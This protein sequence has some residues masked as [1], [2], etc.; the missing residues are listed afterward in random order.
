MITITIDEKEVKTEQG[1]TILEAANSAGI[2]IPTFCW[3]EKLDLYGGCRLCLVEVDELPKLQPACATYVCEG[4]KVSTNSPKVVKARKGVLEF[5]LINH[6][7][8][9]PTC[10]KA[11]ECELQDQV[12]KYGSDFTRFKEKKRRFKVDPK[13][14]FDDLSIGPQMIRNMNRCILCTRCIRFMKDIAGEHKLG[15][16]NRGSK[17]QINALPGIP[18]ANQYAGNVTEICP[19]GALTSKAFRYKTRVWLTKVKNS[20]CP[21]CGDGCNITLWVKDDKIYRVTSRRND[22]VDEGFLCDKGR[23]GYAFVNHPQ[24]ITGPLVKKEGKFE[25]ITWE[26]AFETVASKFKSS[27]QEF[28]SDSLAGVGSPNLTNEDN[29]VFQKFLR[30]AVGTNNIDHRID[31]K[32]PLPGPSTGD[33][34][35][36]YS[37]TNSIEDIEKAKAILVLGC[38]M[39]REHPIIAL[40][41]RKA[42]R[43]S[44]AALILLNPRKTRLRNAATEELVYRYGSEVAL[45]NCLLSAMIEQGLYA[46]DKIS[47]EEIKDLK[48]WLETYGPGKVGEITGIGSEKIKKLAKTLF[49]AE[50]IIILSGREV[51]QHHQNKDVIDSVLNILSLSGKMGKKGC[52]F[53]LLWETCNSQG[54]LDTGILPDRLPG[55]ADVKENQGLK[56]AQMLDAVNQGKIKA[57]Y[58][59]GSDPVRYFPDRNYV[60]STLKKLDFL[61]VQDI[62]LTQTAKMADVVLPG[63]SFAEKEGTFTS[64]E[65]RIQKLK[66]AFRP[67]ADSRADWEIISEL[68]SWM[69]QE[70]GYLNAGDVTIRVL[71]TYSRLSQVNEQALD[72]Q[73]ERWILRDFSSIDKFKKVDYQPRAEDAEYPMILMTGNTLHHFRS[74]TQKSEE[75]NLIEKEG[76]CQVNPEDAKKQGIESGDWIALESPSGR[77]E[78]KAQIS[79]EIQ[80]GTVFVPLNFEEIKVNILMDKDKLADRVRIRKV[81]SKE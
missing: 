32:N 1:K 62:F 72:E 6:P 9:C 41:I 67:L 47:D 26:Q 24:R 58:I 8:D 45:I 20:I 77:I 71:K 10:D 30:H 57:M 55:L 44:K 17:S 52:G 80:E 27:K 74:L 42:V 50:T 59:M 53:N 43:Q 25:P 16:F 18:V 76:L 73:G 31:T 36:F 49:E 70:F 19:V 38:D 79:H 15:E 61:V 75:I 39:N 37:M 81:Q 2:D 64:A 4:M 29:F 78:I 34:R 46:R 69:G 11:G 63:A 21:L 35:E 5:L 23:F 66:R 7:L 56:F 68:A 48:E 33:L 51:I 13:S 60:E 28:G 12:F 54:A 40:R 14:T 65:R 3:H 22:K